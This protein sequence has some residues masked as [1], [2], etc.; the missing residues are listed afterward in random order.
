MASPKVIVLPRFTSEVAMAGPSAT[1][2]AP[3]SN[4]HLTTLSD[5]TK[6]RRAEVDAALDR[7]T[8]FDSGCPASLS[9]AIR[10]SLLSD[11]KRLRPLLVLM[12][13]EACGCDFMKAMPAAAAVEMIH[14]YS[15]IHDDLPAMDDDDLR[16]GRPSCHKAF[17]EA[18]AILAGDA[19]LAHAFEVISQTKAAPSIVAQC[20][21]EL[22]KAAGPGQ[23][24]GGQAADLAAE[25]RESD[26]AHLESIHRRKTGAMFVVSLKLGG[27]IGEASPEQLAA[28]TTYGQTVGLA[29]QIVDDLLDC[30]VSTEE[31]GKRTHKDAKKGKLTFP[32]LLGVAESR[33]RAQQLI[34]QGIGALAPLGGGGD[35]LTEL[36]K[37]ILERKR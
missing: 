14:T 16:R 35:L 7:L 20:C 34:E 3:P 11:G 31:M 33:W 13:C 26:A 23:L 27:L 25:G 30:E 12:A 29:F 36:A 32:R 15:L 8:H 18:A 5:W 22:A 6:R 4:A 28:L 24:V 17:G 19:L 2:I 37:Y 1:D 21:G 10:Y 9:E